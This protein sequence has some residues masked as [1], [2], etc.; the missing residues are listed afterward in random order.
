MTRAHVL[1]N[2]L[3][4]Y[5]TPRNR[6]LDFGQ[7]AAVLGGCGVDTHTSQGK[8]WLSEACEAGPL[9]L[10]FYNDNHWWKGRFVL[11][12]PCS[13]SLRQEN[14]QS[15]RCWLMSVVRVL[16]FV[17]NRE[18]DTAHILLNRTPLWSE[19]RE[20]GSFRHGLKENGFR[21]WLVVL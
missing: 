9:H 13:S 16:C 19:V 14:H 10:P 1:K 8:G 5:L 15:A 18:K 6:L 7:L 2:M 11:K 20:D 17:P 12:T 21:V 3:N 4:S